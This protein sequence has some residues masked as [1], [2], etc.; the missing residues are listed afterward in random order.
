MCADSAGVCRIGLVV[1]R[2]L[3]ALLAVAAE[4]HRPPALGSLGGRVG[5]PEEFRVALRGGPIVVYVAHHGLHGRI[6]GAV[7]FGDHFG[8][9]P[10]DEG[11]RFVYQESV[12]SLIVVVAYS[13]DDLCGVAGRVDDGRCGVGE[14]EFSGVVE[15]AVESGEALVFDKDGGE[16]DVVGVGRGQ[17]V[18]HVVDVGV[19]VL[20]GAGRVV[21][22]GLRDD[23]GVRRR[24]E[25][26]GGR[27]V[28]VEYGGRDVAPL[29]PGNC[30]WL[31]L[32][33]V[34][35]HRK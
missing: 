17:G 32:E 20:D 9:V 6:P 28:R 2:A 33:I 30:E 27:A 26:C 21:G 25:D 24:H 22:G 10:R 18:D 8:V 5:L 16:V 12:V 7:V 15:Y 4:V 29:Q 3:A 34:N 23:G 31:H 14:V 13:S 11:V 35:M 1:R 19:G